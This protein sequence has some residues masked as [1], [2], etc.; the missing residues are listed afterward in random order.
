MSER[1]LLTVEEPRRYFLVPRERLDLRGPD[2]LPPGELELRSIE[3]Q[4]FVLSGVD[5]AVFEVERARAIAHVDAGVERA[6]GPVLELFGTDPQSV[7]FF[8]LSPG[9]VVVDPDKRR[10]GR[11]TLLEQAGRIVRP[12]LSAA[13]IDQ[14][15]RQLDSLGETVEA[16]VGEAERRVVGWGQQLLASLRDLAGPGKPSGRRPGDE[17]T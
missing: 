5:V 6:I 2:P 15:E 12:D 1:L 9:E 7:R 10:E 13:D 11:R 3:G 14:V 4:R 17:E 16:A 8:G